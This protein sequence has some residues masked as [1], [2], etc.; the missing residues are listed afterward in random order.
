[1]SATAHCG[2]C[3]AKFVYRPQPG[4]GPPPCCGK[5]RCRALA[6]WTSEDWAGRAR[7]ARARQAADRIAAPGPHDRDGKP[8]SVWVQP[9]DDLDRR[10]LQRTDG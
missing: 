10:A 6:T 3:R 1:V 4:Q 9:L 7:T 2:P 5:L 8:T